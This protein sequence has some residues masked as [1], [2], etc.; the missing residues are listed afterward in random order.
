MT[1]ILDLT[2]E[3]IHRRVYVID[4][5]PVF[6]QS[7][8]EGENVGVLLYNRGRINQPDYE[9]CVAYMDTKSI[10]MQRALLELRLATEKELATAYKLLAQQLLPASI[11]MVNGDYRWRETDAFIGRVPEG[12][13]E[14][15][16][17]LFSGVRDYVSPTQIMSFFQGREDV[18]LV[19]S[20]EYAALLPFFRRVFSGVRIGS[21]ID[22]KTTYRNLSRNAG[23]AAPQINLQLFALATSG[24]I[25]FL[26]LAKTTSWMLSSTK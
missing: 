20:S 9:R 12:K 17:V 23:D 7:N 1:G 26:R 18:P 22:G 5:S 19:K 8:A 16:H 2:G 3:G 25:L 15:A 6:M 13:F 14:P 11:G 21:K 4:G 24:M 10:T